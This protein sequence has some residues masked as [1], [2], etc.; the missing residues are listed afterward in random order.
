[1]GGVAMITAATFLAFYTM[2]TQ[3][4][5]TAQKVSLPVTESQVCN[6]TEG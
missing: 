6:T 5:E 2:P 3:K 4:E 1:M